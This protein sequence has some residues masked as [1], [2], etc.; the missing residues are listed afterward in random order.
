MI[1]LNKRLILVGLVLLAGCAAGVAPKGGML[2]PGRDRIAVFPIEN[3]TGV[4][5]PV[6]ELRRA[7][8]ES[9]KKRG[10][11]VLEEDRLEEVM[12]AHRVR[13]TGGVDGDTAR[14]FGEEA[15]VGA[16]LLTALELYD[17]KTPP[18]LA[19]V[20][21]LVT[22]QNPPVVVWMD[23][24]GL[25]GD[26]SPG[27]LGLGVVEDP[28]RLRDK[29]VGIIT[30]SLV[31]AM[32][33]KK[34]V[35]QAGRWFHPRFAYRSPILDPSRSYTMAVLPFSNQ[36]PRANA[37]ALVELHLV[38]ELSRVP[39]LTVI[40]PGV[41]RKELLK[42]RMVMREGV[43]LAD[44]QLLQVAL[45]VDLVVSGKVL[46]YLDVEGSWGKPSVDF[47]TWIIEKRSREVVWASRSRAEG[48]D[49]VFFFDWGRMYTA[50]VMAS[51]MARGVV[52][53]IIR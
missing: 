11:V 12:A 14:V 50:N 53:R 29:T 42:F 10:L 32:A 28:E 5:A 13:Y 44:A 17:P 25:S 7:L 3:L 46:E 9:L 41:V 19:L 38:R 20:C 23:G 49:G 18:K 2:A 33:G 47:S 34:G 16:V 22:A 45:E 39:N 24:V 51:R 31:D 6:D 27:L 43:S 21:R 15:G 37:G 40:E 26:Q 48:D 8:I 52:E 36:T 1:S 30:A 35:E 4:K